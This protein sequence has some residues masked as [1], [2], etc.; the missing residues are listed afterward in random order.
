MTQPPAPADDDLARENLRLRRRVAELAEALAAS[1]RSEALF[2]SLA[3]NSPDIIARF[4]REFCYEYVSPA[5]ARLVGRPAHDLLGKTN[6]E[7]GRPPDQVRL[8]EG[9]LRRVFQTGL[10]RRLE[11]THLL[12]GEERQFESVLTPEMEPAGHVRSVLVYTRDVSQLS[13]AQAELRRSQHWFR[14]FLDN[15][16]GLAFIVD[17]AG[18]Y[19]FLN[20]RFAR[21]MGVDPARLPHAGSRPSLPP[22]LLNMFEEQNQ[23]VVT[24][25][26]PHD[27]VDTLPP[28]TGEKIWLAHKFPIPGTGEEAL[29]GAVV[30]DISDQ[31]KLERELRQSQKMEALGTLAG[32]IAHD[33]NNMNYAI[34]GNAEMAQD[35]VEPGS[36]AYRHLEQI[37]A[38][39]RRAA[40]LTSQ[41]LT[42]SRRGEEVLGPL[43]VQTVVKEA[44]KML[45]ATLPASIDLALTLEAPEAMVLAAPTM[46]HQVLLNLCTNSRHALGEASGRIEVSLDLT[47]PTAPENADRPWLRLRVQD[48]GPGIPPQHLERIFDPFFTTKPQGQGSGLGLSLVLGIVQ[49]LGGRVEA[50][51]PP[52]EG[53]SFTILL[54]LADPRTTAAAQGPA[55]DRRAAAPAGYRIL[56][57]D[58]DPMVC[59][60]AAAL[61]QSLG[62][63]VAAHTASPAALLALRENPAGFDLL[64]SEI[65]LPALSG[66]ELAQEA[67]A[68]RPDLP[69][70]LCTGQGELPTPEEQA[71]LGLAACF[72][73]PLER[74]QLAAILAAVLERPGAP[75]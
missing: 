31:I 57:V 55:P 65:C 19:H 58:S 18:N 8:W 22:E 51:S 32:G 52:G 68:L 49:T 4:N 26:R 54:P 3:E 53:A 48:S 11:F 64:L 36:V 56:L 63:Q 2:R 25:G 74:R 14:L 6:R 17:L 15:L 72:R 21:I 27:F 10:P 50:A 40:E 33:F 66:R 43:T 71:A 35:Q 75:A 9:E 70:V 20:D 38:A 47:R 45:R 60:M 42:F 44:C 5:L 39:C 30:F 46:L 67:R 61:L 7:T 41:L 34:L 12:D 1:Q 23:A 62:F 29:I 69:V 16:P 24:T 28:L 73:K 59:R 37:K 13:Q